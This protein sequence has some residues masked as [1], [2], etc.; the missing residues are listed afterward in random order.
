MSAVGLQGQQSH[1]GGGVC[2]HTSGKKF[3]I[4]YIYD[5]NRSS[6]VKVLSRKN[7]FTDKQRKNL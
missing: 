6:K 3:I 2:L 7:S 4:S 1:L 5:I